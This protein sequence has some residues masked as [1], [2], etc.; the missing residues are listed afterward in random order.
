MVLSKDEKELLAAYTK[1]PHVVIPEG[2]E[3]AYGFTDNKYLES[4]T[5]PKSIRKIGS[6]CFDNCPKL[7]EVIL[8]EGLEECGAQSFLENKNLRYVD[9]P[10]TLTDLGYQT[11]ADCPNLEIVILRS[12]KKLEF[13]DCFVEYLHDEPMANATLYV[14][15]DL[16]EQYQQDPEWS[17]FKCIMPI[18]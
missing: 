1:C 4:V 18:K 11:F 15:V 13:G 16:V 7:R 14:P 9:L 10:S 17:V 2:V 12:P 6:C 5:F 3:V 8:P